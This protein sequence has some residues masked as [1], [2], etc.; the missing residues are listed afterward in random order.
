[1]KKLTLLLILIIV[2]ASGQDTFFNTI[3]DSLK[4]DSLMVF[5]KNQT[6]DELK[7]DSIKK[8]DFK[9]SISNLFKKLNDSI[10][11]NDDLLK[12]DP[13]IDEIIKDYNDKKIG[14]KLA[15]NF[16]PEKKENYFNDKKTIFYKINYENILISKLLESSK[17]HYE[18]IGDVDVENLRKKINE[19]ESKY[20][21]EPFTKE[22]ELDYHN[23]YSI[24][25]KNF[26]IYKFINDK[27]EEIIDSNKI[28][29]QH[30]L[31]YTNGAVKL[32][33]FNFSFPN[34]LNSKLK[35]LQEKSKIEN[36]IKLYETRITNFNI[37]QGEFEKV[38]H[39]IDSLN[40]K[41]ENTNAILN[42]FIE[43]EKWYDTMTL[44]REA[45]YELNPLPISNTKKINWIMNYD[46]R[47][48]LNLMSNNSLKN[49]KK[50]Y[51]VFDEDELLVAVHF[52]HSNSKVNLTS[53]ETKFEV[54]SKLETLIIT[55]IMENLGQS[56]TFNTQKIFENLKD[57]EN[58]KKERDL[59]LKRL[60]WMEE[61]SDP[62][63]EIVLKDNNLPLYR[64]EIFYP[65]K[66]L[67]NKENKKNYTIYLKS[68]KDSLVLSNSY[69]KYK[70]VYFL[71]TVGVGF[72]P[73]T[74]S[75]AIYNELTKTFET[76]RFY[77]NV[78]LFAGVKWYPF[79]VNRSSDRKTTKY[80]R[81]KNNN[82]ECN[83]K[84]FKANFDRGNTWVNRL[85]S[86]FSLGTSK[87]FLKNYNVGIG[88][89]PIPGF[90][91]QIG[92]NI[93]IQN[94]Y[95][96]QNQKIQDKGIQPNLTWYTGISVDLGIANQ[97]SK[98]FVKII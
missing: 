12:G 3:K 4:L 10:K 25:S 40:I 1:M 13:K 92:G 75:N 6:F 69:F 41:S 81:K 77:N 24:L 50:P 64:T 20:L 33:P 86:T 29:I 57:K 8:I 39:T 67:E 2:N 68:T 47:N 14:K 65:E 5:Q 52:I 45:Y 88:W 66:K 79:G 94:K 87:Q 7:F 93:Y 84:G 11:V 71:P 56:E 60:K 55:P 9:N 76:D 96:I 62:I 49:F 35:I 90:N 91:F 97:I 63:K 51:S 72:Y 58:K 30:W 15:D 74:R 28:W 17:S 70:K 43:F 22:I 31:W 27:F 85:S 16:L 95:N 23:N 32:N 59:A 21:I 38:K 73:Q 80:I 19:V 46:A 26:E 54:V 18:G 82:G 42:K 53:K 61:Q 36:E 44:Q 48:N 78:E 37:K 98:L 83:F 89:D 34:D